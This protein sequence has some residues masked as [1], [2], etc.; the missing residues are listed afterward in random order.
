MKVQG[1][2]KATQCWRRTI[3]SQHL[4]S[5]PPCLPLSGGTQPQPVQLANL[6]NSTSLKLCPSFSSSNIFSWRNTWPP[7]SWLCKQTPRQ[8]AGNRPGNVA[9]MR[10]QTRSLKHQER[11]SSL[12][13]RKSQAQ[14]LARTFLQSPPSSAF[15]SLFL[16]ASSW[17]SLCTRL[18]LVSLCVQNST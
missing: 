14:V 2:S 4:I 17:F 10:P 8:H 16:A 18:C 5:I 11:A 7:P 12:R 9:L 3:T 15:D 1:R 6:S 13:D